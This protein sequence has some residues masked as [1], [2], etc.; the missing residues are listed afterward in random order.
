MIEDANRD[1]RVRLL[2]END[3]HILNAIIRQ[4]L[5][6][7]MKAQRHANI[8]TIRRLEQEV[9]MSRVNEERLLEMI[10]QT[11]NAIDNLIQSLKLK[12]QLLNVRWKSL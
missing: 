10:K 8:Q 3:E 11:G 9:A 4:E 5:D 1:E 2:V 12:K 6:I 7:T